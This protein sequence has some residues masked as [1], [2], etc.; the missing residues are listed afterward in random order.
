MLTHEP[1]WG[2]ARRHSASPPEGCM[3]TPNGSPRLVHCTWQVEVM[4][5]SGV[6]NPPAQKGHASLPL[7]YTCPVSSPTASS[8]INLPWAISWPH[9]SQHTWAHCCP[10][11][12]PTG[13][14]WPQD[15]RSPLEQ[16]TS[17]VLIS[18]S[19]FIRFGSKTWRT[20]QIIDVNDFWS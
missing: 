10:S 6:K 12:G 13:L 20:H 19:W 7:S 11:Q 14:P 15:P 18:A 16:G 2:G 5:S 17:P 3:R 8:L 9:K 4:A 1:C